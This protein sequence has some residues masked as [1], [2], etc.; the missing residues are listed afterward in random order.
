MVYYINES[1]DILLEKA[2]KEEKER[3]KAEKITIRLEKAKRTK[4]L[5]SIRDTI[6]E[7]CRMKSKEYN[8]MSKGEKHDLTKEEKGAYFGMKDAAIITKRRSLFINGDSNT[9]K[10]DIGSKGSAAAMGVGAVFGII[11]VPGDGAG[12]HNVDSIMY[13]KDELIQ[14]INHKCLYNVTLRSEHSPATLIVKV[15]NMK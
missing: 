2:T 5:N 9:I 12:N 6:K 8:K 10:F 15:E 1:N 13:F 3:K 4:I 7:F 11:Y 14:F